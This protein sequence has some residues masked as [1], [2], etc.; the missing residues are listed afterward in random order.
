MRTSETSYRLKFSLDLKT[1]NETGL[2]KHLTG[3]AQLKRGIV[4]V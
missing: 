2:K 3:W 4:P 1:F